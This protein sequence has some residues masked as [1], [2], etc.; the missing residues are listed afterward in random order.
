MKEN[1]VMSVKLA[2]DAEGSPTYVSITAG[3]Y[4]PESMA[5]T[6]T[7]NFAKKDVELPVDTRTFLGVMNVLNPKN[8]YTMSLSNNL[9]ALFG[10][11]SQ[12]KA[13]IY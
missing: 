3:Y 5:K 9:K 7:E 4:T 6:I 1:G 2:K 13:N 10:V 12:V 11:V 8:R